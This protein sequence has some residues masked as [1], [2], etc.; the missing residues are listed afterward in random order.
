VL[1][2]GKRQ[3]TFDASTLNERQIVE[4]IVGGALDQEYPAKCSGLDANSAVLEAFKLSGDGFR[5]I[6]L[7]VRRGE[8]LGLAGIIGNG[9]REFLQALGGLGRSASP[10]RIN[11][12]IVNLRSPQSD[13]RSGVGYLPGDRHRDGIFADLSVKE[14]FAIRSVSNDAIC[15]VVKL[16][17]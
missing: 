14:N 8:I 17:N 13:W 10:I 5:D 9:Q 2:D 1:R 3:G 6:A 4:L 15:G 16:S 11:S 12:E 7:R